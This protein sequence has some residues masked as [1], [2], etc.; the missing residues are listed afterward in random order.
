MSEAYKSSGG[1]EKA[2]RVE[3]KSRETLNESDFNAQADYISMAV[4]SEQVHSK[5]MQKAHETYVKNEP[6]P[7]LV[8]FGK[9]ML[10]AP[11]AVAEHAEKDRISARQVAL[12]K[13]GKDISGEDSVAKQ[14][15]VRLTCAYNQMI[16]SLVA[17]HEDSMPPKKL[18]SWLSRASGNKSAW[19]EPA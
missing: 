3:T 2:R 15:S 17:D 10:L 9:L 14:R 6:D 5:G 16:E 1:P 18:E 13:Q 11:R 19:A 12:R 7:E 4:A 8:K